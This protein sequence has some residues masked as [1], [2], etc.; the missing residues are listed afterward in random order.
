MAENR[1]KI[2]KDKADLVQELT[3]APGTTGAF[4]TYADAIAFSA[5]LGAKH[6]KRVRLGEIYRKEPARLP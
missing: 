2:A 3:V 4:Q 5:V 1:I 6:K